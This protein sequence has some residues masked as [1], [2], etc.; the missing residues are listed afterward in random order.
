MRSISRPG[1]ATIDLDAVGQRLD[2]LVHVGA[3]VDGDDAAADRPWPAGASSS[4]TW[5]GELAG[6]HEDEA[7]GPAG[8]G[9]VEPL[10]EGQA[11]GERLARAGLGLAA[12]VAAGEGVGD[13][14]ALDGEGLG[15]ALVGEGLDEAG[16]DA[17]RT[18]R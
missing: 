12:H 14:E 2:L 7:A 5:S 8:L 17:E 15:D 10:E 1:V 16:G 9:L 4:C 18:R 3:A 13:R 11:E 6:G